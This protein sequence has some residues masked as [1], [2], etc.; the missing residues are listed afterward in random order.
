MRK[1][2]EIKKISIEWNGFNE[3]INEVKIKSENRI[4]SPYFIN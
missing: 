4:E 2:K 1:W 3:D